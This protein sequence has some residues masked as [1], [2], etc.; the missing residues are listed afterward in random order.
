MPSIW[1]I[2][3]SVA[4]ASAGGNGAVSAVASLTTLATMGTEIPFGIIPRGAADAF[5]VTLGIPT[6]IQAA[7]R[8]APCDHLP[9]KSFLL[10]FPFSWSVR[11]I[12]APFTKF[13]AG[14]CPPRIRKFLLVLCTKCSWSQPSFFGHPLQTRF[15]HCPPGLSSI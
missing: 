1:Q 8:N 13:F 6:A 5:S 12:F 9:K 7:S 11:Q 10:E 4:L 14:W 3:C 2:H 15:K